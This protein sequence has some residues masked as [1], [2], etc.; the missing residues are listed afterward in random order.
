MLFNAQTSAR[1]PTR[2]EAAA[3]GFTSSLG[4]LAANGYIPGLHEMARDLGTDFVQMAQTLTV[5]LLIYAV[6]S[7]F[8]GTISDMLGRKKTL[9]AGMLIFTAASIGAALATDFWTLCFWRMIQGV[10]AAVGQV[11]T[12]AIVRDQW[13]GAHAARMNGMIAMFFAVSPAVAPILGGWIIAWSSWHVLFIFMGCYSLAIALFTQFGIEETLAEADRRPMNFLGVMRDYRLGFSHPAFMAGVLA[14]G[15]A[16]MGG[17]LYSAGGADFVIRIMK[18][19]IDQFA[20]YTIPTVAFTLLGAWGSVRLLRRMSPQKMVY[21]LSTVSLL[22]CLLIAAVEYCYPVGFP[23][24]LLCPCLYWFLCSLI[25]PVMM[26]MNMD[27]FPRNRGMAASIQ[28]CFVTAGFGVS[29]ALWVPLVMGE[30]WKYALVSGFCSL[31]VLFL[32]KVSMSYR[33]QFLQKHGVRDSL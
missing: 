25:R 12:Q 17:I 6:C 7:V 10:G 33:P 8:M 22:L 4:P 16:F 1:A 26:V 31:A 29:S 13:S 2:G 24:V 27:Y 28:Q 9:V 15:F 30:A 3:L 20:W 11:V 14:H 19:G 21:G 23:W 18:L 32:W 5:Y